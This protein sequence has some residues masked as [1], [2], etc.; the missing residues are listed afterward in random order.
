MEADMLLSMTWVIRHESHFDT[1]SE[2]T[3]NCDKICVLSADQHAK[4]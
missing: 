3:K 1:A 4:A 2:N